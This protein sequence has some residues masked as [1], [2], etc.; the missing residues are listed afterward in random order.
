MLIW[1]VQFFSSINII[2]TVML[3]CIELNQCHCHVTR[4]ALWR[5]AVSPEAYVHLRSEMLTSHACL[6]VC[7]W[8][9][10]IGDRH[11]ENTLVSRQSGRFIGIDF[12]HAFGTATQNLSIPE[13]IPCRLTPQILNLAA[14]LHHAGQDLLRYWWYLGPVFSWAFIVLLH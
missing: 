4:E 2:Q 5:L 10:G 1:S 13:L 12:G 9:L 6:C 3:V 14:P 7:H 8:L 11:L